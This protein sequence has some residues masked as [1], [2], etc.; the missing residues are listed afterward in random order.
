MARKKAGR[1]GYA[2]GL[3]DT[4]WALIAPLIPEATDP[5]SETRSL[6]CMGSL[7]VARTPVISKPHVPRRTYGRNVPCCPRQP[8]R[9]VLKRAP[10]PKA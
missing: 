4:Q 1:R 10:P 8:G 3:G 7:Q 2:T 6:A 5:W 9:R